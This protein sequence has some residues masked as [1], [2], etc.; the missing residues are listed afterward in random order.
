MDLWMYL[1]VIGMFLIATVATVWLTLWTIQRGRRAAEASAN[2]PP[3]GDQPQR[4]VRTVSTRTISTK[5]SVDATT[6]SAPP[7]GD[8]P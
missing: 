8:T 5:T 1:V 2:E 4:T 7:A 3:T 6:D